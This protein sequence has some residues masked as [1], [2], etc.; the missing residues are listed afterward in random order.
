MEDLDFWFKKPGNDKPS[1][2]DRQIAIIRRVR[3]RLVNQ[4]WALHGLERAY[5]Q[6][7]KRGDEREQTIAELRSRIYDLERRSA[8]KPGLLERLLGFFWGYG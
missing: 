2:I 7:I 3:K 5:C 4:R 8:H 1:R 6:E